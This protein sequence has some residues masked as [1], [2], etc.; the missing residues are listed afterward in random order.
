[1]IFILNN[2]WFFADFVCEKTAV[3][4]WHFIDFHMILY[5]YLI[6]KYQYKLM[7]KN[8]EYMIYYWFILRKYN[9]IYAY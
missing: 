1:M 7:I 2:H 4:S 3:K 9:D 6:T 8:W 5:K